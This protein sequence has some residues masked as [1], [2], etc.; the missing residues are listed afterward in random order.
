MRVA[1]GCPV[2]N[3]A[4]IFPHWVEHVRTA[5]DVVGL[6]PHW[7][8][9]IGIGPT[10]HDD[11][12]HK[13]ATDLYKT[14]PGIWCDINEPETKTTRENWTDER[15]S[16]MADYRNRLL[17]M[18][19]VDQPD[20]FLSVDSDIL[21]HP[22]ALMT[23]LDTISK[24]HMVAGALTEYAAVGGKTFLSEASRH[25]TTYGTL[26]SNGGIRRQDSDGVFSTEI[27]MALKLMS[28]AAYNIPYSYHRSG[29]DIGWSL[30]CKAAGLTLGW[31]GRITSK[32]CMRP[33]H[34]ERVDRRV[35][36]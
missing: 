22:C 18:V 17:E 20:L 36:W 25:L 23:L 10:G 9:A 11:G 16:Q 34:L 6:K 29:E 13:M 15:L 8:F 27:L 2:R 26:N 7:I 33:E 28:P 12:T 14:D 3:R 31:D 32:H 1:V 5:F 4:W 19:R 35:G 30:N 21:L 24:E